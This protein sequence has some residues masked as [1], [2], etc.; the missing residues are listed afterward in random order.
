MA[1]TFGHPDA[2]FRLLRILAPDQSDACS[3]T[4]RDGT[5][6]PNGM[7]QAN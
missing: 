7:M 6:F 3:V 1:N 5:L 4:V 2:C